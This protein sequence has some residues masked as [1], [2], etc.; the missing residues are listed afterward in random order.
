MMIERGFTPN[1]ETV[2]MRLATFPPL[3][4]PYNEVFAIYV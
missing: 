1:R 3:E 2:N 4:R